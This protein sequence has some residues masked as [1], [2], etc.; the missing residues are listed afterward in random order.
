VLTGSLDADVFS[1]HGGAKQQTIRKKQKTAV[2]CLKNKG[3]HHLI[4]LII[5][6]LAPDLDLIQIREFCK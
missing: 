2:F 4:S 6:V 5:P 1:A 3:K